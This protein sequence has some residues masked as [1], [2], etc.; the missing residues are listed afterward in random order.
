MK[1]AHGIDGAFYFDNTDAIPITAGNPVA[2]ALATKASTAWAQFAA[3]GTPSAPGLPDWPQYK[4]PERETMVFSAEPHVESDPLGA[5]RQLR[6]RL[7]PP[8]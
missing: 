5:D 4:L 1:A 8:V 6:E 2:A 7:A 3:T